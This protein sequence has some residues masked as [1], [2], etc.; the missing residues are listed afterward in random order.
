ML[1]IPNTL[2]KNSLWCFKFL[3]MNMYETNDSKIKRFFVYFQSLASFL[4]HQGSKQQ[5]AY[6]KDYNWTMQSKKTTT[7][8]LCVAWLLPKAFIWLRYVA[9]YLEYWPGS[10]YLH[11]IVMSWTFHQLL[12]LFSVIPLLCYICFV[13]VLC[14]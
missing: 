1:F 4:S 2:L 7:F 13:V 9:G 3:S 10:L 14:S 8:E 11:E 5:E 12:L 6:L